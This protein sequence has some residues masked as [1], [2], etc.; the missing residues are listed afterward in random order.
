MHAM[1]MAYG[2]DLGKN[3]LKEMRNRNLIVK[4]DDQTVTI[5]NKYPKARHHYLVISREDVPDL[6]SLRPA[7]LGLLKQMHENG[8]ALVKEC[9]EREPQ[10]EF[11]CGYHAFPSQER[12]HLH[13]ISQDFISSGLFTKEHWNKYT[14]GFFID[15][16]EVEDILQRNGEVKL[17]ES[18]YKP[19][20]ELPLK[21]HVCNMEQS[22]IGILKT[23]ISHKH[24][25]D[26]PSRGMRRR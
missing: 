9:I 8:K 1:A 12:L 25:L 10:L 5:M 15:P 7:H 6:E 13:V 18:T 4:S 22:N 19:M 24:A 2:D 16:S 20:L 3:L 17:S 23:H 14:T 21:C 26:P 11:K